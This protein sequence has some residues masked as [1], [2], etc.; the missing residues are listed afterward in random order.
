M[1]NKKPNGA[2]RVS[3]WNAFLS[4]LN[5]GTIEEK[6]CIKIDRLGKVEMMDPNIGPT[7]GELADV[8]RDMNE[9]DMEELKQKALSI[10]QKKNMM[11]LMTIVNVQQ[12]L[13]ISSPSCNAAS[14]ITK[15]MTTPGSVTS[16]AIIAGG[17]KQKFED[18]YIC[19]CLKHGPALSRESTKK[20][21][22]Q[23]AE[24]LGRYCDAA[25]DDNITRIDRSK[26]SCVEID[27]KVVYRHSER[28]V[29]IH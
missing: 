11:L 16:N 2:K 9:A 23:T 8:Y 22:K 10:D 25:G 6:T 3:R 27:G 15:T 24:L 13:I 19:R 4:L 14:D 29:E 12:P 26:S 17:L 1:Q 21:S 7:M 28:D 20:K 5:K 18:I